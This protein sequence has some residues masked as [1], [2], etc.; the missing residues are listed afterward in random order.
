MTVLI[1]R[2][3][4]ESTPSHYRAYTF[5]VLSYLTPTVVRTATPTPSGRLAME[6]KGKLVLATVVSYC[7][8]VVHG[9]SAGRKGDGERRGRPH[10]D[11]PSLQ[12]ALKEKRR[13]V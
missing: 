9:G 10:P 2:V 6:S 13:D 11:A 3:W 1:S 4:N 5:I 8:S 12:E 7:P